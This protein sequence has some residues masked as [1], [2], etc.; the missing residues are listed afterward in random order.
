[1]TTITGQEPYAPAPYVPQRPI[2]RRRPLATSVVVLA[3]LAAIVG[4]IVG[5]EKWQD[6]RER[7]AHVRYCATHASV[8]IKSDLGTQTYI[9][10]TQRVPGGQIDTA[11]WETPVQKY[12]LGLIPHEGTVTNSITLRWVR[13]VL[14]G[15]WFTYNGEKYQVDLR[16]VSPAFA[17]GC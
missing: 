2:W 15:T 17:P 12:W 9:T 4:A 3:V 1:M 6:S 13:G 14:T 16:D 8:A 7:A 10:V 5:V 11:T